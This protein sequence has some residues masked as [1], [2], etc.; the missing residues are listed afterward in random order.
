MRR[1]AAPTCF[2]FVTAWLTR[3][4]LLGWA[5]LAR[6]LAGRLALDPA[7]EALSRSVGVR[8]RPVLL[9][10]PLAAV[11]VDSP[12]DLALVEQVLAER[13]QSC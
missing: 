13:G 3:S 7:F 2:C 10:D 6:F 5:N 8:V 4:S 12:A 1:S 9:D 11:D